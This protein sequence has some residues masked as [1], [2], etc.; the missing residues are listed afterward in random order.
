MSETKV[1]L[2]TGVSSGIGECVATTL[3]AEGYRVFGSVRSAKAAV[4]QGV[5]RA[6][7]DVRDDASIAN[8]ID[9]ILKKAGRI[10]G[11]VN[12]AGASLL[13]AVEETDLAQA[14]NLFDINFFGAV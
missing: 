7:L 2:V 5:E 6:V 10:D 4:P 3:A 12:N 14:Q 11:L 8:A 9:D 13:G 1:A